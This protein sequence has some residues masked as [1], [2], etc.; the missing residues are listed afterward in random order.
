MITILRVWL[1]INAFLLVGS[2]LCYLHVP[3]RVSGG[4][5]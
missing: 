5:Q 3:R 1:D 2:C 4:F